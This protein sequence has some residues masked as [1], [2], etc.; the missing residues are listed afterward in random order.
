LIVANAGGWRAR[1]IASALGA[2]VLA[3][4]QANRTNTTQPA[5]ATAPT[6][7]PTSVPP[8][9]AAS[10]PLPTASGVVCPNPLPTLPAS[11]DGGADPACY[12]TTELAVDGWLAEDQIGVDQGEKSPAWTIAWSSLYATS[13]SVGEYVFDFLLADHR[14]G[15]RVVTPPES[16]IDLSGAG[17]WVSLRGH[18]NDPAASACTFVDPELA[19]DPNSPPECEDLFVVTSLAEM[20]K[21]VPACPAA[22]PLTLP[23]FFGADAQCF[24]GR[25]VQL[26][27]WEDVGEGFGGASTAY[28]IILDPSM[29]FEDAQLVSHRWESDQDHDAIFPWTI[30]GGGVRFDRSDIRVVV[31]GRLGHDAAEGCL[32]G[33]AGWT[34]VPPDSWAQHRCQHIFVITGVRDR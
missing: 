15:I 17:R 21:A 7:V 3:G 26:T 16:G 30:R 18:F 27:G 4:C 9:T 28:P 14:H 31:T 29:R 13:P 32:P 33:D 8:S 34:W 11:P 12:G 5:S 24:V 25:D 20:P 23:A 19:A 22:S 1:A 2:V 10:A 6:A